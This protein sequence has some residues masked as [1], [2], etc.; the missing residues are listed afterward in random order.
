MDDA[1]IDLRRLLGLLRRQ[2]R[3]IIITFALTVTAASFVI[4]TLT[5]I[6]AAAALILVDPARKDLLNPEAQAFATGGESAKVDSEVEILGSNSVLLR[7]VG[8]GALVADGSAAWTPS[9]PQRLLA[10]VGLGALDPP[11]PQATR[12]AALDELRASMKAQRV[13][14]TYVI[15][16]QVRSPQ[17]QRAAELANAVADAYIAQQVEAKVD[18][19]L[20]WLD[21][22]QGR[23]ADA[24]ANIMVFP[25]AADTQVADLARHQ[26]QRLLELEQDLATR[27]SLQVADSRVVSPAL[28]NSNPVFP[29]RP[30]LLALAALGALT[31]GV[32]LAFAHENFV[33]GFTR[34]DQA[35]AVLK[36][37][38]PA[39]VPR[40]KGSSSEVSAQ[41]VDA[42]L[43]LFAES[44]R[45]LRAAI[46]QREPAS[47]Q[48]AA[49]RS[50]VVMVTSTAPGEGKTTIAVSL[51]RSYASTGRKVLLID[52]DLR[53][54]SVQR[55]LSVEPL[56]GLLDYLTSGS[57]SP[58]DLKTII[59]PDPR[60]SAT[61]ILGSG[62]S[63]AP[64]DHLVTLPVF[65]SLIHAARQTFEIVILDTPPVGPAVDALYMA[66]LVDTV[67]FVAKWASTPQSDAKAALNGLKAA[68][69]DAQALV[70][71]N[72]Q[73]EARSVYQRKYGNYY[74]EA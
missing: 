74:A 44:I 61:M 37:S 67:V 10:L 12:T 48:P 53:K 5:P 42:P 63:S 43:S 64:T 52:A 7:V 66:R 36:T 65:E 35:E 54:P 32:V 29:N 6:Y 58:T 59:T 56:V 20:S 72:Q 21:I 25:D 45:R 68:A 9:L 60:S 39:V 34:E 62:R 69:P 51:A 28:E 13:G 4:W 55:H 19:V 30:L 33:G 73:S 46:D 23:I 11:S 14:Q 31:L 17:P 71:L 41:L 2:V 3:L 26:Y 70:V 27:A 15:S 8:S 57:D 22:M 18:S 40:Q 24:R 50:Q 1:E 49:T 16:V 47:H 38:V